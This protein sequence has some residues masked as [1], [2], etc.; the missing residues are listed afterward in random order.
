MVVEVCAD[1]ALPQPPTAFNRSV[2]WSVR[3]TAAAKSVVMTTAGEVVV[4]A[5][6]PRHI[7]WTTCARLSAC[8]IASSLPAEMTAVEVTAA[9]V[10]AAKSALRANALSLLALA[11][12]VVMMD[13]V[14]TAVAATMA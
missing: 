12:N 5:P 13:A 6:R 9:G 14:V 11:K 4:P 3:P 7:A 2:L 8:P 10:G 1:N